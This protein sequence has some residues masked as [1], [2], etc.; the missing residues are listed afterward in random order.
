MDFDGTNL[1]LYDLINDE[2][3]S[4]NLKNEKPTVAAELKK[5]LM[6]WFKNYPHDIDLK[7]Y[8]VELLKE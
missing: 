7:K 8:Q 6:A 2:G 1:Q 3:E 5:D 4:K